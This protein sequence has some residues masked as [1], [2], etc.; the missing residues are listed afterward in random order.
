MPPADK[1][2]L[3]KLEELKN[4]LFTKNYEVKTSRL[5]S[6]SSNNKNVQDSWNDKEEVEIGTRVK[7]LKRKAQTRRFFIFSIIFFLI[8]IGYAGYVYLKGGNTVSNKNID[9]SV[10]GNSFTTGGEDFPLVI[11]ITN[12]NTSSLELVDLVVEYP[13]GSV[14]DSSADTERIRE[15]IGTIPAGTEHNESLKIVLFGQQGDVREVKISI[16]YRISG[17][18][19]IFVKDKLYDVTINSSPIS[20]SLD[21]PTEISPNQKLTLNVKETL[22]ST[23][24]MPG[25]LVKLDYPFGFQFE[26]ATPAPTYDNDVWDLGS[27]AP[28]EDHNITIT[29]KMVNVF[30]GEQKTFHVTSGSQSST[31]KSIVGVTF[32]SV[33]KTISIQKP[34]IEAKLYV[35]G[36]YK[37]EY[38][39][40]TMTPIGGEIRWV[41]NLSTKVNDVQI[42]AKITGNALDR[43]TIDPKEGFYNSIDNSINWNK[44]FN[45]K[46]AE[47]NPGD[48]GSVSFS[49]SPLASV[50]SVSNPSI[51]IEISISGKEPL[52]GNVTKTI[53]SVDS[54]II[55]IT[56][57]LGLATKALYYSGSFTNSGP[58]PPVAEKETTYTINWSLS[59]T[60][61]SISNAIVSSSLPA[62]VRFVGTIAPTTEDLKYDPDSRQIVWNIGSIS[63]NVSS[64]GK[65]REVSFQVALSPSLSQVNQAPV[66]IN[67]AILTG[68]D[69]FAKVNI[70]VSRNSLNTILINDPA[71]PANGSRVVDPGTNVIPN[72]TTNTTQ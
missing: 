58:I 12:R 56:S 32:N 25:M 6:F 59:N 21:A 9:I 70:K 20:L 40:D 68:Y 47:I 64:S 29:G 39:S 54:Q 34:F 30:E 36:V 7:K 8:A 31:D 62:W 69:D 51:N 15:S 16:E 37:S 41:N 14:G 35:N 11:G 5:D 65:S 27:L 28:G 13:K 46:F 2:K 17:S 71:F 33:E 22:N 63:K 45:S 67:S 3:N 66:L 43:R 24:A 19:A 44:D 26:S 72:D 50:D 10:M 18:N 53:N 60:T 48:A 23:K 42:S 55:R 1:D 57:G 49:F 52:E 61:N 38:A 4:K